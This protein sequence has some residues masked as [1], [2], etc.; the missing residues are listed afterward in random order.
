MEGFS[1]CAFLGGN[2]RAGQEFGTLYY[3]NFMVWLKDTDNTGDNGD[4]SILI[5]AAACV[6]ALGAAAAV[7]V[8]RRSQK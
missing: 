8:R 2:L 6:L 7:G 3:D 4:A 5:F 1:S